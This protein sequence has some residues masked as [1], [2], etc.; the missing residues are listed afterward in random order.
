MGPPTRGIVEVA[1][2]RRRRRASPRAGP[3]RVL[4]GHSRY[5]P[6]WGGASTP[7]HAQ[8]DLCPGWLHRPGAVAVSPQRCSRLPS[9]AAGPRC[10]A[11]GHCGQSRA[12]EVHRRRPLNTISAP[13][14]PIDPGH[15]AYRPRVEAASPFRPGQP[16][17]RPSGYVGHGPSEER[18]PTAGASSIRCLPQM[19]PPPWG[20]AGIVPASQP[21][22]QHR[23]P[24]TLAVRRVLRVG[25]GPARYPCPPSLL[26]GRSESPP[27]NTIP[28][29]LPSA[30][31]PRGASPRPK[32]ADDPLPGGYPQGNRS[33]RGIRRIPCGAPR[34][35]DPGHPPS[36]PGAVTVAPSDR[37]RPPRRL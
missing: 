32:P 3:R 17:T 33:M 4:L 36:G 30:H 16:N 7:A 12:E 35:Q 22:R 18:G 15:C 20:T 9:C 2:P 28:A 34:V 24:S 8:Y 31:S 23:S 21:S 26:H 5:D 10:V 27:G 25:V 19:A 13:G 14:G 37:L 6:G 29:P 11:M 1:H